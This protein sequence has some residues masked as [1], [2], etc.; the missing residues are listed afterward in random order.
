MDRLKAY[1]RTIRLYYADTKGHHDILDYGRC[2]LL[3][4]TVIAAIYFIGWITGS[5]R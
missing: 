1:L 3:I 5:W 4:M 2:I